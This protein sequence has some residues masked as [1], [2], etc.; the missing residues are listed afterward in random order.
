M[1]EQEIL[2]GIGQVVV[3]ATVL[4]YYLAILVAVIEG[5]GPEG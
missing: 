5:R 1:E 2:A 3:N 4:E